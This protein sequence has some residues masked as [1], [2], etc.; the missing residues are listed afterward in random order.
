MA[1]NFAPPRQTLYNI[2]DYK[3]TLYVNYGDFH[4]HTVFSLHGLS[5]PTEVVDMAVKRG[6][7]YVGVGDHFY[8]MEPVNQEYDRF[9]N[10]Y[11]IAIRPDP[12]DYRRNKD[13]YQIKNQVARVNELWAMND[14]LKEIFK[15]TPVQ[16][17][18]MYE[19]NLFTFNVG[20]E[21]IETP[22]LRIL[23]LHDWFVDLSKLETNALISEIDVML[24]RGG[25]SIFAHPERELTR[26]PDFEENEDRFC[27][28]L[29]SLLD[30]YDVIMEINT[31]TIKR[32][33]P[34]DL[35]ILTKMTR[36]AKEK[37]LPVVVDSDAHHKWAVGDCIEGF[38]LL[39]SEDYPVGL[40]TNFDADRCEKLKEGT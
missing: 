7:T 18:P 19:Y 8:P 14:S 29:I 40:I 6:I 38:K 10:C 4:C 28:E 21:Q 26:I 5:S 3:D 2:I 36:L 35:E 25:F 34:R 30:I 1:F 15:Y 17:V 27:N 32:G 33:N 13:H 16:V 37:N 24:D 39:E 22:H 12:F 23:G 31:R 11:D 9:G 20:E